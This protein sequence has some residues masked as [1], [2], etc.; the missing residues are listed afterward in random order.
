MVTC[1]QSEVGW[2]ELCDVYQSHRHVQEKQ[3]GSTR[4]RK[5]ASYEVLGSSA[6]METLGAALNCVSLFL[7][8]REVGI[9][10]CRLGKL[11]T[12]RKFQQS[13]IQ[14]SNRMVRLETRGN[15]SEHKEMY[16]KR[17]WSQVSN[18]V[19]DFGW[20]NSSWIWNGQKVKRGLDGVTPHLESMT[21]V[22]PISKRKWATCSIHKPVVDHHLDSTT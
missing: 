16:C 13:V 20:I 18:C 12:S 3:G 5:L 14:T 1:Y 22:Q 19:L 11:F 6:N 15:K 17:T 9:S 10:G 8:Q 4:E 2:F 21:G 7:A